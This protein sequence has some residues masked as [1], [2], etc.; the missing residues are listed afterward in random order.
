MTPVNRASPGKLSVEVRDRVGWIVFDNPGR[1]NAL[2]INMMVMLREALTAFDNDPDVAV[3][4]LRG[5]G[6]QAFA[7]G[8]DISEFEENQSSVEAQQRFDDSAAAV[9]D[10]LRH[11]TTPTISLIAGYC[12]GGG[13][14]VALGTD[15]RI[16]AADST[17]GIPAARLGLGYPLTNVAALVNIV[18]P[19]NALELL[20]TARRVV[21]EEAATIGLINRVVPQ[22]QLEMTVA[23]VAAAIA[24]NAPLTIAAAKASV[25][26]AVD[27][28]D[29]RLRED[30]ERRIR[31]CAES[32]DVREGQRAFMQKRAPAFTGR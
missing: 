5:A 15:I 18:G 27:T 31:Q 26:A 23:D 13:L 8:V 24:R 3:V 25:R 19:A 28:S 22:E 12:L 29:H 10:C 32:Q 21:A 7:S 4:V 20:Y 9:F 6:S 14:A 17:F 16:A 1:L 11:M 2:S 30:A